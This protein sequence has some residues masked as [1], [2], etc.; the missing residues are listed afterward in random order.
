MVQ[1]TKCFRKCKYGW[2]LAGKRTV[3][4]ESGMDVTIETQTASCNSLFVSPD[5]SCH[6]PCLTSSD[7]RVD[8]ASLL[9]PFSEAAQ[10]YSNF[11][12]GLNCQKSRAG[13]P[14]QCQKVGTMAPGLPIEATLKSQ[15]PL[16]IMNTETS[17]EQ[18][19]KFSTFNDLV[20]VWFSSL[21]F[22]GSLFIDLVQ[23][24]DP[25]TVADRSIPWYLSHSW[26]SSQ[27][28][29]KMTSFLRF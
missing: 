5:F 16:A 26:R 14:R 27:E 21:S 17:F 11:M 7:M 23:N 6:L 29:R 28:I 12:T 24:K 20:Q 1:L 19:I 22:V 15:V 18:T 9:S 2:K 10:I 4:L 3:C 25:S 8:L 13:T